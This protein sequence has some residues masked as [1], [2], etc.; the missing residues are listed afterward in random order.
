MTTTKSLT[1]ERLQ[2]LAEAGVRNRV[3]DLEMELAVYHKVWPDVFISATAPVLLKA[4]PKSESNG[5]W[6]VTT[7]TK[8]T[9][10]SKASKHRASSWTP[11]RRAKQSQLTKARWK[12]G[13]Y[14]SKVKKSARLDRV[15]AYL[16]KHGESSTTDLMAAGGYKKSSSLINAV[17]VRLRSGIIQRTGRGRYALGS[18]A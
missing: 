12:N 16:K 18:K 6:P 7:F 11:K 10:E 5:H 9:K 14:K 8:T 15:M 4:M 2:Q 1:K 3:A 17:A 13:V